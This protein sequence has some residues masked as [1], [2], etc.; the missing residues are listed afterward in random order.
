MKTRKTLLA[1]LFAAS[2]LLPQV[3]WAEPFT[4]DELL[5]VTKLAL[6]KFK[7]DHA[8]HAEGFTGYKAWK[9]GD[10]AKVKIYVTHSGANME[11]NYLCERH[12][13]G[14]DCHDQ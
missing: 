13:D 11:V 14:L 4:P 5:E 2:L 9:S 8:D 7:V 3:A 12:D 6:D 1:G 10:S